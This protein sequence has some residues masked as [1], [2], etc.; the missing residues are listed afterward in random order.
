MSKQKL[1]DYIIGIGVL[2]TSIVGILGH[3]RYLGVI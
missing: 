3:M 1:D 2:L